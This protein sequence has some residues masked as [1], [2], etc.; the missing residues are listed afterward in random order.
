[1]TESLVV[2]GAALRAVVGRIAVAADTVTGR[3]ADELGTMAAP[4][5]AALADSAI[6]RA[7]TL[8]R[9]AIELRQLGDALNDWL[10]DVRR[11]EADLAGGDEGNASRLG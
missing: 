9:L 2:D 10:L 1:V 5:A 6:S 11:Y 3:Y 7:G 4:I 8:P